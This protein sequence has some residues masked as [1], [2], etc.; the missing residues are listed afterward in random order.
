MNEIPDMGINLTIKKEH[1]KN[2]LQWYIV[3]NYDSSPTGS[4]I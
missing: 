4:L 1:K 3:L 2:S